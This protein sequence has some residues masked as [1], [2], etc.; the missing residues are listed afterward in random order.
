M[1]EVTIKDIVKICSGRLVCGQEDIVCHHFSKDTRQIEEG[2]I[3]VGIKGGNFDGSKFYEDAFAKGAS[4]CII[5]NIEKEDL[6]KVKYADKAIVQVKDSIK[7]L[8]QIA[9]YKRS[10]YQIPVIGI[11]GSVG[12]TSTKDLVAGVVSKKYHVLKTEG[13]LNNHIGVPLTILGLENHEALVVEMGMSALGEIRT[14]T[15]IVKPDIAIITNIG[16]SH[17]GDLGSRENILKAKLEIIEGLKE[18][19]TLLIN[20]DNDLLHKW[21]KKNK[22]KEKSYQV[23]TYGIECDSDIM[24]REIKLEEDDSIFHTDINGKDTTVYV[25]IGGTPFIYN[26]LAGILVGMLLKIDTESILEGIKYFKLTKNRMD[27][28][29]NKNKVTI[30]DGTYNASYDAL[31]PA[32]QYL[33]NKSGNKKIAMLGN[34]LDLGEYEESLHEAVGEEL[35]KNKIDILVTVGE[36][37]KYTIQ[38]ALELGM[39]KENIYV[40]KNNQEAIQILRKIM[41][42]NDVVLVKASHAMHFTEIVKEIK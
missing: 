11:T 38:K 24:A 1:K 25:P 5:E 29:V 8:Q 21:Y 19:G 20:N 12:K 3:Y 18:N 17:I 31:K 42:P 23:L 34:I 15:N 13:N 4:A 10:L 22:N 36:N 35:V 37:M 39:R 32:I 27:I 41:E 2:D 7:A 14:L 26:S 33:A 9:S 16:T 6:A 28:Y 40:C 30:I